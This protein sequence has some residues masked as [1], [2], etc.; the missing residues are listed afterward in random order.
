MICYI[1]FLVSL[2]GGEEVKV[3][4]FV[5]GMRNSGSVLS[6]ASGRTGLCQYQ[7]PS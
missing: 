1:C 4:V 2:E 6:V 3:L 5:E 7:N